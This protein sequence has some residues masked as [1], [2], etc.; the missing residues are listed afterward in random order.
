MYNDKLDK[1]L[2]FRTVTDMADDD[3]DTGSTNT[4]PTSLCIPADSLVGIAPIS[5]T[6]ISMT[7]ESCR[8]RKMNSRMGTG[9]HTSPTDEV[10]LVVTQGKTAEVMKGIVQAINGYSR[11]KDGF[12]VIADDCVTTDSATSALNDLTIASE[13]IHPDITSVGAITCNIQPGGYG[14]HEYYEVVTPAT[15]DNN[16]VAASL[17]VKIPAQAVLLDASITSVEKAT[18]NH[19]ALALEYHNAAIADDAASGGTEWVG[20]DAANDLSIP[21]ANLDLDN[22]AG[23]LGATVYSGNA[24]VAVARGTAETFIH[25]CAKEDLS[26]MTGNPKVGIYVRW[27]G[28]PAI[29]L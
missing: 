25:L 12:L 23:V 19:G 18:S 4:A 15:A 3:G 21:D 27:I 5:D 1:W 17:S 13:F 16:D 28:L 2:Y 11:G 24:Q 6:S 7:F 29:L 20:A 9:T 8:S 26:S 22:T 14:I 10:L